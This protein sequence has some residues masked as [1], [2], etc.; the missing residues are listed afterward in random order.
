LESTD[1]TLQERL[2]GST[3]SRFLRLELGQRQLCPRGR[4]WKQ[5]RGR[6][7]RRCPVR[8][9]KTDCGANSVCSEC[10]SRGQSLDPTAVAGDLFFDGLL[11]KTRVVTNASL[12]TPAEGGLLVGGDGAFT[13][14][15]IQLG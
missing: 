1:S 14:E 4:L 7:S 2:L 3:D 15:A 8:N 5:A 11:V 9:P 6:E 10:A 13:D 12:N